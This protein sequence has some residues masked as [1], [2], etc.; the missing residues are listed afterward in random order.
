VAEPR[1]QST[2]VAALIV[3]RAHSECLAISTSV[4]IGLVIH[5]LIL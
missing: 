3:A 2:N 5:M 4:E 1:S